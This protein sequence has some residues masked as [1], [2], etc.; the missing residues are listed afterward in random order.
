MERVSIYRPIPV[1]H[2]LPEHE[3]L[4]PDGA[5]V[6]TDEP[7]STHDC[8]PEIIVYTFSL[9]VVFQGFGE[10]YNVTYPSFTMVHNSFSCPISPPPPP[11]ILPSPPRLLAAADGFVSV[12]LLFWDVV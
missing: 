1:L 7:T 11:L 4:P 6:N 8:Q 2:L 10:M 3:H 12:V 9:C 5:F